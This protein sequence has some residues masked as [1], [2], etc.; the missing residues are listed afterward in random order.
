MMASMGRRRKEFEEEPAE[1]PPEQEAAP[2]SRDESEPEDERDWREARSPQEA[3][4]RLQRTAGNQ[5]ALRVIQ[6]LALPGL[7]PEEREKQGGV[8]TFDL[9]KLKGRKPAE[10]VAAF[11]EISDDLP[12]EVRE[13]VNDA[14]KIVEHP[15]ELSLFARQLK[16]V[17]QSQLGRIPREELHDLDAVVDKLCAGVA[18]AWMLWKFQ[19]M[20][21]NVVIN[22]VTAVGGEI[23]GPS[24]GP[25]VLAMARPSTEAEVQAAGALSGALGEVFSRWQKSVKIP[26][27]PLYPSFAAVPSPTAPPTPSVPVPLIAFTSELTAFAG[28]DRKVA[29]QD[30]TAAMAARAV[31]F[32]FATLFPAWVAETMVM[33]LGQGPVP[34]FAPPYVPVGPV[35]GGTVLPVP[36]CFI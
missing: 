20:M 30:P 28:L 26:G 11:K 21:T 18:D 10:Q 36:G 13:F 3:V 7:S 29:A 9:G 31:A 27:L 35:V 22:A 14:A 5:R 32:A 15:P 2:P 25:L 4:L 24:I 16:V 17:A 8:E 12:A 33:L 34:T 19:A 1:R 6:R 23:V